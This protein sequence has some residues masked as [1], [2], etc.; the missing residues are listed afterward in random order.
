MHL[1]VSVRIIDSKGRRV[2]GDGIAELL[3]LVEETGTIASAARSMNMAYSKAWK[4][5]R[6]FE[7]ALGK[8]ALHCEKG[9][10]KKGSAILTPD[11]KRLL[12]TFIST[13]KNCISFV[14]KSE[15]S[16]LAYFK[17]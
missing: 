6:N 4:I 10:R 12:K 16:L 5:I 17:R 7:R 15:K 1:K 9:G 3:M 11:A 13:R 2:F 8:K 14:K